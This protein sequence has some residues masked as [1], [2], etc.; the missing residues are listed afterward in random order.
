MAE[1]EIGRLI[2]FDQIERE[3]L[4]KQPAV[5]DV[6]RPHIIGVTLHEIRP[7]RIQRRSSPSAVVCRA[8]GRA[9][10][11]AL[12]FSLDHF[13]HLHALAFEFDIRVARNRMIIDREKHIAGLHEF[14]RRAGVR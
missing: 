6:A 3:R 14:C 12:E 4:K 9:S 2:S 5:N 10:P 13:R 8:R 11:F 7:D 1:P